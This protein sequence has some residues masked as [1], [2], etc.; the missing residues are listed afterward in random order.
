MP[1]YVPKRGLTRR[2]RCGIDIYLTLLNF[3]ASGID[4]DGHRA[5]S[6]ATLNSRIFIST[7]PVVDRILPIDEGCHRKKRDEPDAVPG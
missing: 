1:K 3:D 7:V 5:R 6:N 4:V 2:V